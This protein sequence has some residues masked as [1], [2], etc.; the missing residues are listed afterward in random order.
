MAEDLPITPHP[1]ANTLEFQRSV[2]L[3]YQSDRRT[4]KIAPHEGRVA[5][6][7]KAAIIFAPRLA[8]HRRL[9]LNTYQDGIDITLT[10][11]HSLNS[12]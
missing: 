2:L 1:T 6:S 7:A 3:I 10:F 9:S 12:V 8:M 4:N 11:D 5:Q